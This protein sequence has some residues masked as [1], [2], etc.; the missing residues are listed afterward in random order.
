M[1]LSISDL[2]ADCSPGE[3]TLGEPDRERD[4]RIKDMVMGQI[5]K[6]ERAR[7]FQARRW[8]RTLALVAAIAAMLTATAYAAGLFQL[9]MD[10]PDPETEVSGTWIERNEDGSIE[11]MQTLRYP[12]AGFVFT[13][14]SEVSP[15]RVQFKPGWLPEHSEG[16]E[17]GEPDAEGWYDYLS[18]N[19]VDRQ[20]PYVIHVIYMCQGYTLVLNGDCEV[21]KEGKQDDYTLREI[22]ASW[23]PEHIDDGNYLLLIDEEEGYAIVVSG[24]NSMEDM[25]RIAENLEIRVTDEEVNFN[26]D[27]NIGILNFGRG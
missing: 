2:V 19:G 24:T 5:R 1:K 23:N 25:E 4:R 10:R 14:E 12:D 21:V 20:I 18:D 22:R 9:H 16:P 7:G 27:Y 26:P 15:H 3:I 13:F 6:Q 11:H 8:I 17:F